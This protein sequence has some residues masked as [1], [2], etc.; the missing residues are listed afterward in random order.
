METNLFATSKKKKVEKFF[1]I[2]RESK[3]FRAE[4]VHSSLGGE[5]PICIPSLQAHWQ[6][7]A[8]DQFFG[9]KGMSDSPS[10]KGSWFAIL[11]KLS[12]ADPCRLPVRED[13]LTQG[14]F[15]HPHV[16]CFFH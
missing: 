16:D 7:L 14:K 12:M 6:S 15:C 5:V 10:L 4:C 13:L 11:Q 1:S 2:H 9:Y 3:P 8:E